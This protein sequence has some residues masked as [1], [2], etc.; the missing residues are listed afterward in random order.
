[1]SETFF[2]TPDYLW[3]SYIAPPDRRF[4]AS[5]V[6]PSDP[7]TMKWEGG[8]SNE[9]QIKRA[10]QWLII[11]AQFNARNCGSCA[12][13]L[14]RKAKSGKRLGRGF[15]R[16]ES[17]KRLEYLRRG[18]TGKAAAYANDADGIEEVTDH[19]AL[20]LLAHPNPLDTGEFFAQSRFLDKELCG[21]AFIN[22]L[23]VDAM[24]R[25]APNKT[26]IIPSR[27]EF[28]GGYRYGQS[29]EIKTIYPADEVD[30]YKHAPSPFSPYL[31]WGWVQSVIMDAD[32]YAASTRNDLSLWVNSARPDYMLKLP[33]GSGEEQAKQAREQINRRFRGPDK[34]R[35]F[36]VTTGEDLIPMQWSPRDLEGVA[37]RTDARD[38]IL[39]AAGV[40]LTFIELSDSNLA[41]SQTGHAQY[42]RTTMLP[43]LC[44]DA[45][46]LTFHLLPR[47]GAEPGEMWFVYDNP[48]PED[49]VA[50]TD[51]AVKLTD[52][53]ILT[54]NDDLAELGYDQIG[55]EGDIRRYKGVPLDALGE[56][57]VSGMGENGSPTLTPKGTMPPP[58]DPSAT[59]M[60]AQ[61]ITAIT[62]V[63][64]EVA[65][66]DL[67]INTA[68][69]LLEAACPGID[70]E[71]FKTML[72]GLKG[73]EPASI[74]R[75]ADAAQAQ[76]DAA[77][78]Q[79]KQLPLG[80]TTSHTHFILKGSHGSCCHGPKHK[81]AAM[82]RVS[83]IE[84]AFETGLRNWFRGVQ[85]TLVG[86]VT[87]A[88]TFTMPPTVPESLGVTLAPLVEEAGKNGFNFGVTEL[89]KHAGEA[90][91]Q[92]IL[93]QPVADFLR[94]HTQETIGS[95]TETIQ[96]AIREQLAQG[97]E[98]GE[99]IGQLT[100]RVKEVAEDLT[101]YGAERI[102]RTETA[103][104]FMA[105]RVA[106]WK[107]SG[108]V[109]GKK[110]LLAPD[111]CEFC[112]ELAKRFNDGIPLGKNFFE[113]GD[114][115]T[116]A[117]GQSMKLDYAAVGGPA[118]HPQCRCSLI[119]VMEEP[120]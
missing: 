56:M 5:T 19:P 109:W 113:K 14:M 79:P 4:I 49:E 12:I 90:R 63:L 106:A 108:N 61:Q 24:Y 55:P 81:D 67:P 64:D 88:G 44:R 8:K 97:V 69:A 68:Q 9:E 34:N 82:D 112:R 18:V 111:A 75:E 21:N 26:A 42:A 15:R 85:P 1:M 46:D 17:R 2:I 40:P 115:L 66:G 23:G 54:I 92:T 53:G 103:R 43:R 38:I 96:L 27:T 35:E 10:T 86:A 22:V 3:K 29:E 65:K 99:S 62:A 48:V 80:K 32:R 70:P 116:L 50:E 7:A 101:D 98:A 110:W 119:S 107:V 25:L 105:S 28:I 13:R 76:L 33:Q 100:Q 91:L 58:A 102:A 84:K 118:L 45:D 87:S 77:K 95:V 104:A 51:R 117:D 89:G 78:Q 57:G 16:V 114:V 59:A 120:K 41:S 73:F 71:K 36:L 39:A 94:Y 11:A 30:H 74:Q 60:A 52:V 20:D 31:G 93:S 37:S 72:A 83:A 47:F 6:R